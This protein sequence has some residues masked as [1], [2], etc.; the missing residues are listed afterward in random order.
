[1]P[2]ILSSFFNRRLISEDFRFDAVVP[3]CPDYEFWGRLG[4]RFP[5]SA[6][7][8][9][10]VSLA[11]AYRTRDSMSFRAESFTQFCRDKLTHL[12]HL[13]AKECAPNDAEVLRRRSSAGIHM[14][15]AE[16]LLGIEPDHSDVFAHCAEAARHDRTYER[17]ARF[18]A[19][20]PS[21]RYD[22]AA[23]TVKRNLIGPRAR[24]MADFEACAPPSHWERAAV[25]G[26]DPLTVRT[27]SAPWGFSLEMTVR[28]RQAIGEYPK[29]GQ[30]WVSIDVEVLEGCV[31]I[32]M[33]TPT[34][35]LIGEHFFRQA[36][37][38]STALI[39]MSDPGTPLMVR[40]GGQASSTCHIYRAELIYDPDPD[41]GEVAPI[42]LWQ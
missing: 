10:D 11:Q 41:T 5:P 23:G 40:S 26:R 17:I 4:F 12:N 14:W 6:F 30:Y 24:K 18:L 7:K 13:I 15:A 1:V 16:Q 38:R 22:A 27:S 33:V 35:E 39:P 20:L 34:Q 19:A 3:T 32:A 8:R 28:D 29:G 31:G 36:E 2:S 25:L 21:I 37:V 42:Q 9:Y